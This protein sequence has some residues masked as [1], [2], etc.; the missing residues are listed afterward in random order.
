VLALK[1]GT[2]TLPTGPWV[3]TRH[4]RPARVSL[5]NQT[6]EE[7]SANRMDAAERSQSHPLRHS[8]LFAKATNG[9]P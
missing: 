3:R 4:E 7:E 6:P 1:G 5:T 2:R 9:M 8:S